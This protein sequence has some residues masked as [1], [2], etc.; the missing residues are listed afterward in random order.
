MSTKTT[1]K[2]IA[3]VAVAALGLGVV[4]SVAPANA[5]DVHT[6]SISV[7]TDKAP[8]AGANG[9]S[10]VHTVRFSSATTASSLTVAPKVTLTSKPATSA[11]VYQAPTTSVG[12]GKF[13]FTSASLTAGSDFGIS[14]GTATGTLITESGYTYVQYKAYLDARYDVAGSYTWT[15]WDDSTTVNGVLNG[16]EVATSFTVVVGGT[17]TTSTYTAT[18]TAWGTTTATGTTIS[19]SNA[20]ALIRVAL[21]DAAGNAT[22]PDT[23]GGVKVTVSG[24]GLVAAVNDDFSVVDSATYVLASGDFDGN[25]Y[26][27][28]NIVNATAEA[29]TVSLSGSGSMA[30]SFTA[31][32]AVTVT[33]AA[34]VPS[35][36]DPLFTAG[37]ASGLDITTA[38]AAGTPGVATANKALSSALTFQ[39]GKSAATPA[40]KDTATIADV[41]GKITGK[42]NANYTLL[43]TESDSDSALTYN[44]TFTVTPVWGSLTAQSFT[45]T[46]ADGDYI[47]VTSDTAVADT[48]TVVSTDSFKTLLGSTNTISVSVVDQ[49]G[50]DWV[51][52]AV[53]AA[54]TGRNATVSVASAITN[55]DGVATLSYKDASTSTT[56][57]VD[58]VTFTA[59]TGVTDTATITYVTSF[60]VSTVLLTTPNTDALGVTETIP[61]ATDIAAGDGAESATGA[62]VTA[63]VKDAAGVALA[64][65]PVVFTV[66]GTTAAVLSTQVTGYTS[67]L[68]KASAKVY[69]WKSGTYTV[70]ATAEGIADTAPVN[71]YQ[72]GEARNITAVLTSPRVVTATVTDRFGN[73]VVGAA[74]T[75]TLSGDAFF[76]TGTNVATGTTSTDG[77]LKFVLL[78]SSS[79]VTL[80]IQ[81]GNPGDSTYQQTDA[82]KGLV[83][84]VNPLDVFT[85]YTA[86]TALVAE[87][88]VGASFDAA[89]NNTFTVS[90]PA[91]VSDASVAADAAAEATDAANAATDA[92]NAAAEAAD[93]ATAAA[94]D[95]AD[96]V[97]ALSTQVSEMVNALKKQITALTNL[98]IK[99]QKKVRA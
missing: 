31:P 46:N 76:G 21:K 87:E 10:V 67:I 90:I 40:K 62:T 95:A 22:S 1:F 57:L 91:V 30:S 53:S 37:S 58:V 85:A 2:R 94:Q 61:T 23:A 65:V 36:A 84:S 47:T 35:T 75:G 26:A 98:V 55:A 99:I 50:A 16:S 70:T 28:V 54:I 12:I 25:G 52:G 64:G 56:S 77:T 20:G 89:G 14:T 6:A 68:G 27:W 60:G 83:A 69:G 7:T 78:E 38:M 11:M 9:T 8:V 81:A 51:G 19:A 48:A 88:G 15:I 24:S 43:V 4:S 45:I 33:F 92:A 3:L 80:K 59:A 41:S 71:F 79:E 82:L 44:G 42:T 34:A 97:A 49:F 93:A 86:G 96:A 39:T 63:T 29:V 74:L 18:T 66:S 32:S 17:G 5:G 13:Q 73:P 72:L